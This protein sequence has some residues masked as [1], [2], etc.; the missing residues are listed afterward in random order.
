MSATT[1]PFPATTAKTDA[2]RSDRI[3]GESGGLNMNKDEQEL[4]SNLR[5]FLAETAPQQTPLPWLI[6]PTG[7][8]GDWLL[9]TLNEPVASF[10]GD[11]AIVNARFA[12][13]AINNFDALLAGLKRINRYFSGDMKYEHG[14]LSGDG[15]GRNCPT[16]AKLVRHLIA[17]AERGI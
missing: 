11:G 7:D 10:E 17:K 15:R 3:Q 13:R 2:L 16:P 14:V 12:Y 5:D 6:N 4:E 1:L 9:G 8:M